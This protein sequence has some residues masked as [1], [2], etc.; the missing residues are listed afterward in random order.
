[1]KNFKEPDNC[2]PVSLCTL[3]D[4]ETIWAWRVVLIRQLSMHRQYGRKRRKRHP[5]FLL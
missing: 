4:M 5:D 2:D 3:T 1:M